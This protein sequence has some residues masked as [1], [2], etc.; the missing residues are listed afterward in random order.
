[1][2]IHFRAKC[3]AIVTEYWITATFSSAEF[4]AGDVDGEEDRTGLDYP[5]F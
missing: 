4:R 1:M 5:L 2:K 3:K